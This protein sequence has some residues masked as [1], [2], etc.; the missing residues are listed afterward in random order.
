[1]V[2]RMRIISRSRINHRPLM[3]KSIHRGR[4]NRPRPS[5][6]R[7]GVCVQGTAVFRT[8]TRLKLRNSNGELLRKKPVLGILVRRLKQI[9]YAHNHGGRERI[10][11]E[12]L[13]EEG[14]AIA[15][16]LSIQG[17]GGIVK[18]EAL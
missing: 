15:A 3:A 8:T 6:V 14:N 7:K 17:V 16:G 9:R 5:R 10:K 18:R 2:L 12:L 1:M 11:F 4:Q 13:G